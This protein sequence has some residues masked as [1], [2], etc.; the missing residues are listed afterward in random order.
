MSTHTKETLVV[1]C[2]LLAI[3]LLFFFGLG[4][5]GLTGADEPRYAEV[6]KE[7]Y[8][9]HDYVTPHLLGQPWFEKPILYYWCAALSFSI[10]GINE[11]AARLPSAM[12]A[13]VLTLSLFFMTRRVFNLET[14]VMSVCIFASSI[15]AIGFSHAASTDML[16][17]ACFS[18]AMIGFFAVLHEPPGA[19]QTWKLMMAYVALGL[20]MLAKGPVGL[21]LASLTLLF[22]FAA[23]KNWEAIKQLRLPMGIGIVML[24]AAPW[25]VLCYRVNGWSFVQAF[26]IHHNLLRFTTNEFQHSRPIWFYAPV[27][28][29]GL[30]PWTFFLTVPLRRL[31]EITHRDFWNNHPQSSFLFLWILIPVAF[32]SLAQSKLP[33]YILPVLVPL[34]IILGRALESSFRTSST[35][36]TGPRLDNSLRIAYALEI[37]FLITLLIFRHAIGVSAHFPVAIASRNIGIA[38]GLSVAALLFAIFSRQGAKITWLCHVLFMALL[39]VMSPWQWLPRL[40][41]ELTARPAA[42]AIAGSSANPQVFTYGVSRE[43][44]YGLDFYL[45]PP[46]TTLNSL[47]EI[48]NHGHLH[49]AFLVLPAKCPV[50]ISKPFAIDGRP[51]FES[52]QIRVVR[53]A[54]S[55]K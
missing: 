26:F 23:A 16:L 19:S 55:S 15:G 20:S 25:Y 50:P 3:L 7:M 34:S 54:E 8:L 18:I 29:I 35:V 30:L 37:I 53:I 36:P 27:L 42:L 10:L 13:F 14:R 6:A 17:T 32:F 28:L 24:V 9:S 40:D 12:A 5:L 43:I 52:S 4:A 41:S 45:S 38:V 44:R 2:G 31:K 11:T 22:Y 1:V 46:P 51:V 47:E 39:V 21:A 48:Q 49:L 33:G